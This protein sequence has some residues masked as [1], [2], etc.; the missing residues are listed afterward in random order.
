LLNVQLAAFQI[1]SGEEQVLQSM[2]MM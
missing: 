2:N 1:Y